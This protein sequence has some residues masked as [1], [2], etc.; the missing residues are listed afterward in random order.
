[1]ARGRWWCCVRN[2][3]GGGVE[4]GQIMMRQAMIMIA[5]L[6]NYDVS[7]PCGTEFCS[8]WD[9]LWCEAEEETS[10]NVLCECKAL[11]S[12]RHIYLDS[13]FLD[14]EDVRSLNL[15]VI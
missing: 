7:Q 10:A 1:M 9:M 3:G 6:L 15:G 11:A 13:S 4:I 14:P 12:I 8:S 2:A 5:P